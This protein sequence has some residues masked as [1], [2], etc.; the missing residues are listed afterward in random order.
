VVS[1]R[2]DPDLPLARWRVRC[3]LVEIRAADLRFTSDEANAY[4]NVATGLD[5]AGRLHQPLGRERD[6]RRHPG[7]RAL[8]SDEQPDATV[9]ALTA[10][11][12]HA[13]VG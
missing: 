1:T 11:I 2:A 9:D 12:D 13:R 6:R 7:S 10:F 3:E 4:L 8:H 5:L